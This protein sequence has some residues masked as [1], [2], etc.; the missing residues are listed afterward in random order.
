M[1]TPSFVGVDAPVKFDIKSM[2]V[3]SRPL[4]VDQA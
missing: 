2:K 1:A 3:R 4:D